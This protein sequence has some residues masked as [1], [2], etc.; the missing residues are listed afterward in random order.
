MNVQQ[1]QHRLP[2]AFWVTT[3]RQM[4]PDNE[5]ITLLL[6]QTVSPHEIQQHGV[7]WS[8]PPVE[9]PSQDGLMTPGPRALR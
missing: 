6:T 5:P 7:I 4:S 2:G 1:R 3:S 8:E 9:A